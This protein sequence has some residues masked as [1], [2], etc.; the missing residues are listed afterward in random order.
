MPKKK[1]DS[2]IEE[3][4]LEEKEEETT[5]EVVEEKPRDP[6]EGDPIDVPIDESFYKPERVTIKQIVEDGTYKSIQV[7]LKR[8][9][10][11]LNTGL[12]SQDVLARKAA[13]WDNIND[14][15]GTR[16]V[17]GIVMSKIF[18]IFN[19]L[20]FGIAAWL[21]SVGAYAKCFFVIIVTANIINN[22]VFNFYFL[23]LPITEYVNS[24]SR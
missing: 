15:K 16:T 18:T 1:K 13:H 14:K 2:L 9:K 5:I 12:D 22:Y 19:L 4:A 7:D 10:A 6:Y 8:K 20:C 11:D 3:E 24:R 23:F 21:I 17:G